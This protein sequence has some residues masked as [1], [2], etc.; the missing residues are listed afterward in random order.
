MSFD[1]YLQAFHRGEFAGIARQR[2]REVFG[3]RLT[4]TE[5]DFWQLRYD[6]SNS[7]DL[8]LTTHDTPRPLA[9]FPHPLDKNAFTLKPSVSQL[10]H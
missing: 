6:D 4:E 9:G 10:H 3:A 2:V 5:P 7:C 8:Y 1:V